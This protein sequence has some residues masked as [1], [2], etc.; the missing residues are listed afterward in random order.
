MKELSLEK[1]QE[2]QGGGFWGCF[3]G[4]VSM[5]AVVGVTAL[6]LSNPAGWALV[7]ADWYLI[8]SAGT[9]SALVIYN[10]C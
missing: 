4:I 3:G 5:T 1:M 6:A 2:L 9:A 10:Q 8:A 7:A